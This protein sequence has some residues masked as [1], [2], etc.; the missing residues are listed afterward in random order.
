M[1]SPPLTQREPSAAW[2]LAL[3]YMALVVYAT[4]YPFSGWHNPGLPPWAYVD[5]PLPQYWTRFDVG[6]NLVG[7]APL[8]C[9]LAVGW[10]RGGRRPWQACLLAFGAGAL[11]SFCLEALQTYLPMR[12]ASNLDWGLN[13]AGALLGGVLAWVL[14]RSGVLERWR[15]L[16]ARWFEPGS[17][18]A[19]VLLALWPVGLLFP[20][21]VALGM[22][23]VL[24]RLRQVLAQ[25]LADTPYADWAAASP[26]ALQPLMRWE[27]VTAVA[28]GV[29]APCL[30]GYSVIERVWRRAL[31][32][33]AVLAAGVAA[34]ALSAGLSYGP[35]HA[36]LWVSGPVQGGL[37]LGAAAAALLLGL[38]RR[39]CVLLLMPA[40]ATQVVLL[41]AAPLNPYYAHTLQAWEQGRF[42][43]FHG[44][45]QWVGWLWP[46]VTFFYLAGR[47]AHG[48]VANV[49]PAGENRYAR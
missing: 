7:Y 49:A 38:P 9:L 47:V 28:L 37:W 12:V 18:G 16:R 8:G 41:N 6:A 4:L 14:D 34:S 26:D 10:L 36:W 19:Q 5:A 42:I 15:R 40:L 44:L 33:L 30:L 23:Q 27:E 48:Y 43:H 29:L 13:A 45:A 46:F 20:A 1:S 17:R 32:A 2:P 22:G 35:M 24:E 3:L 25:W 21:P 31:F 39:A 11:L